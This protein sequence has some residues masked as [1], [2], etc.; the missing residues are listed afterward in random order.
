MKY[1]IQGKTLYELFDDGTVSKEVPLNNTS[2]TMIPDLKEYFKRMTE[3]QIEVAKS[4]KPKKP[5]QSKK[6]KG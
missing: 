3:S 1:K 2:G 6:E 5:R 4:P